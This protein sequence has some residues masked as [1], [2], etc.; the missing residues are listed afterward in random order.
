MTALA[1]KHRPLNFE[2]VKGQD[3]AI[4][5]LKTVL[6]ADTAST[7]LF[8]G[9]SGTGKTTLARITSAYLECDKDLLEIDAA[10][11]SGVDKMREVMELMRY[12]PVGGNGGRAAIVDECHRLS[13]QAWDAL[14]KATEEPK[15]G[16]FWFFC[17]TNLGKVPK[18]IM[19]RC[20]HIQLKPVSDDDLESVVLRVAKKEGIDVTDGVLQ[21]ICR[22]AMGSPRQALANLALAAN[23]TTAKEASALLHSAVDSD[24]VRELCQF[25]LKGGSWPKVMSI[26]S[27]LED[28]SFEGVR[29]VVTNY[30]GAVLK[31][32]KS[33]REAMA[34]LH[35]IEQFSN[36][37]NQSEGIAPLLLSVGRSIYSGGE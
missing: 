3:K 21:I 8:S 34:T 18:T 23:A 27:R 32:A 37:Y 14:L 7:F 9:P 36:E 26:L 28:E 30:M 22:E 10:S 1:T 35:I 13:G 29:I 17:T 16:V 31:G 33:D 19:T 24:A 20:A 6:D 5:A 4:K 11:N 12:T 15:K 2:T 25:L